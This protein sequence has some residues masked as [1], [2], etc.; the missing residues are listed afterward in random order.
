MVVTST[1]VRPTRSSRSCPA[2]L[3][4]AVF[5]RSCK[6]SNYKMLLP[7]GYGRKVATSDATAAYLSFIGGLPHPSVATFRQRPARQPLFARRPQADPPDTSRPLSPTGPSIRPP[8][9]SIRSALSLV[10]SRPSR[11]KINSRPSSDADEPSFHADCRPA[12]LRVP[13]RPVLTAR[14][15]RPFTPIARP[16]RQHGTVRLHPP[17]LHP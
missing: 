11:I 15:P 13:A 2:P 8:A 14:S 3:D 5:V 12:T 1:D 17:R 16:A 7:R 9:R 4:G 6:V 10:L